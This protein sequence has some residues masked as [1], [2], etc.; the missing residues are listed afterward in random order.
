MRAADEPAGVGW[1]VYL[2][3][4]IAAAPFGFVAAAAAC[5]AGLFVAGVA[6]GATAGEAATRAAV[7]VVV[8]GVPG[9]VMRFCY[10]RRLDRAWARL[11][12]GDVRP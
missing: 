6:L 10:R 3:G 11:R 2:L 5:G 7:G 9:G 4:Y 1:P 12:R 8:T